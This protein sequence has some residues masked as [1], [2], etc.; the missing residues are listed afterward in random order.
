MS[1]HFQFLAGALVGALAIGCG[2]QQP[3]TA[4][5]TDIPTPSYSATVEHVTAPFPFGVFGYS[6][7][8]RTLIFG[9]PFEDLVE[10]CPDPIPPVD[11]M[12]QIAVTRPDGSIK[13]LAVGKDMNVIV[14]EEAGAADCAELLDAPRYTGTARVLT[15]D[16]DL[17]VSG[18]RGEST[19][20]QVTGTLA[21][22]SGQK[23]H[24]VSINHFVLAPD[25]T[26]LNSKVTIQLTPIGG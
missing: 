21:N 6:D 17:F 20:I 18:N 26:V 15:T 3:L 10:F 9:A 7:G 1:R 16:N 2:D 24:L 22:E 23:F 5:A 25:G 14:F 11:L 12:K 19:L 8:T 13:H 4:P